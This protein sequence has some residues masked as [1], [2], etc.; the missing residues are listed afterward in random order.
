MKRFAQGFVLA[1]VAALNA[2]PVQAA[3]SNLEPYQLVRSLQLVQDRIAGGDH[4]ALPMQRR[5]LSMIDEK[6]RNIDA[7]NFGERRNIRGLLIYAMSGG[8]PATVERAL[9]VVPGDDPEGRMGE[10]ILAY[11]K[12]RPGPAIQSFA[13]IDPYQESPEIAPSLALVKGG[14][15]ALENPKAALPYLDFARLAGPGTLV[16][17][18]ALRR[19]IGIATTIRDEARFL[20]HSEQYVRR[21]LN[22]PYA[23]QFAESFVSGVIAFA[24]KLE[25]ADIDRIARLMTPEQQKV[26]YLR[27]ARFAAIEGLKEL[28]LTA[29]ARAAETNPGGPVTDDPRARLYAGMSAVTSATVEEVYEDLKSI[30]AQQLTPRDRALLEAT[31]AIAVTVLSTVPEPAAI[32]PVQPA[33]TDM[34]AAIQDSEA[35]LSSTMPAAGPTSDPASSQADEKIATARNALAEIDELLKDTP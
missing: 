25:V 17:E 16:E 24:Q 35:P 22:S 28:S 1:A 23:A 33:Q 8:N 2:V 21:F 15:L 4:A 18:A 7:G 26:I 9:A 3:G 13:T 27:I 32:A 31:R 29:S 10:A 20:L 6:F 12:G 30:D 11:L 19:S 5:L 34:R 14:L